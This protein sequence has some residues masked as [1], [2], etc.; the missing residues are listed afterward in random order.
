MFPPKPPA[1]LPNKKPSRSDQ[2]AG[3]LMQAASRRADA[4]ANQG[5][6]QAQLAMT[7]ARFLEHEAEGLLALAGP[8]AQAPSGEILP[9]DCPL[10]DTLAE[11]GQVAVDA[12]AERLGLLND[13]DAVAAGL[14]AADT[15]QARNSLERMLAHQLGACHVQAMRCM[16]AARDQ[17]D[18]I[19]PAQRAFKVPPQ[20]E[21]AARLFNAAARLQEVYQRGLQ[22]AAKIRSG[23][24]QTVKVVHI[25]QAVQV[26]EGGQAVVAGNLPAGG[27]PGRGG[28]HDG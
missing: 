13:L 27:H 28:R 21:G 12:S 24:Q 8:V 4:A 20:V 3:K 25:H 15:I 23:G 2:A 5:T 18:N 1:S 6:P 16:K 17:L 10:V 19:P 9:P 22:T 7:D 26:Q 14:D 11:P